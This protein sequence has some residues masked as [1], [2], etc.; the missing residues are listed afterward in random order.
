[1]NTATTINIAKVPRIEVLK[2][3]IEMQEKHYNTTTDPGYKSYLHRDIY[4]MKQE[5]NN[6]LNN[7]QYDN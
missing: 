1:M 6:I 3:N 4:R 7:K 5:L 2:V